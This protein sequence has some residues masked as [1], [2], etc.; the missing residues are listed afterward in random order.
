MATIIP[1]LES[2]KAP[3]D[4]TEHGSV[5]DGRAMRYALIAFGWLNVALAPSA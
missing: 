1:E 5:F 3:R 4:E 2:D